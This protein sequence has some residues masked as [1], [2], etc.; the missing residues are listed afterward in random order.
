M[1]TATR[2]RP[3][4]SASV[5][6]IGGGVLGLS[7][8]Y[9]LARRGIRDV[10]VLDRDDVGS[11]STC[12]AAGG[13]RAQFSDPVNIVLGA[14]SLETFRDFPAS[15]GQEIDF[16]QVGYLFLLSTPKAVAAFE[17]NVALQNDL[18]VPS[19]M[20][21]AREAGRLSPLVS[22]DGLLAAA[23]SRPTGT[24]RPKPLCWATPPRPSAR[25]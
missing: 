2:R 8:A 9:A 14:R 10:V 11:G 17:A 4:A 20:I 23:Y 22:T 5:V 15:F 16:S 19:R 18:G 25:G 1:T 13:V 3:P 24:A 12:K 7:S 6:V 21:S